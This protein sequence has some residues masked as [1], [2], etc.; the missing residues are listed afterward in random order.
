MSR[1]SRLYLVYASKG[2]PLVL[3]LT[4]AKGTFRA[5][6]LD[7]ATGKLERIAGGTIE[8]GR[9]VTFETP[10]GARAWLLWLCRERL[11]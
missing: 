9:E 4:G 3:N 8:G 2:G 10:A 5:R 6:W 7:P 11:N 1:S